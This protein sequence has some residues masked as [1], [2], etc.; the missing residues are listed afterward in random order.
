[1]ATVWGDRTVCTSTGWF[2]AAGR[3]AA[4]LAWVRP[5]ALMA[6]SAASVERNKVIINPNSVGLIR[7][8]SVVLIARWIGLLGIDKPL[9]TQPT[10]ITA[11]TG[12][13]ISVGLIARHGQTVVYAKRRAQLYDLRFAQLQ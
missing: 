1:M 12:T 8:R 5:K 9:F 3:L 10:T 4:G 11:T 6:S 7:G 2:G 13:T